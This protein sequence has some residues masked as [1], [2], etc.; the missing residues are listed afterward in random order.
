MK[1]VRG[2]FGVVALALVVGAVGLA[3]GGGGGVKDGDARLE[4]QG[5]VKVRTTSA[6]RTITDTAT[7]H[8]GDVIDATEGT[9]QLT[10]PSGAEL[11]GRAAHGPVTAT[12]LR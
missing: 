9:F 1:R 3:C 2:R 11:D 7:V 5:S 12:S 4:V 8:D 10:L 6:V